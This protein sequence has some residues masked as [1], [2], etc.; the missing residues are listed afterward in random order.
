MK[1]PCVKDKALTRSKNSNDKITHEERVEMVDM[2]TSLRI[3][4][5]KLIARAETLEKTIPKSKWNSEAWENLERC[6]KIVAK[7]R[8]DL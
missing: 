5:E 2:K 8:G 4:G 6:R 7:I 1:K 3:W